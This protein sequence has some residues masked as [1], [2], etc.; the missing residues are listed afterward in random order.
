MEKKINS[1]LG[2]ILAIL[3]L[4]VLA[5]GFLYG[6]AKVAFEYGLESFQKWDRKW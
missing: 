5:I 1:F 4:P 2:S 3:L 6:A